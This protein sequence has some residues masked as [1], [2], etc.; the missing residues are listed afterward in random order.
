MSAHDHAAPRRRRDHQP[1]VRDTGRPDPPPGED[2]RG[3]GRYVRL[4]PGGQHDHSPR[5]PGHPDPG[6]E[7]RGRTGLHHR[8]GDRGQARP[9]H[10]LPLRRGRG[11]A[12]P[13]RDRR[14][15]H[16]PLPRLDRSAP[17]RQ[18]HNEEVTGTRYY[19]AAGQTLA[20]RTAT[21]GTAGTRLSFLAADHHGT[22]S[23]AT[24]ATTQAVTKRYSTPFGAPRGTKPTAWPDDKAFLGK[25]ADS[26]TGLT[27]IGARA[28]DPGVGQFI[29]VDPLL[30][31]D[32][33]QTLN[34]YSYA[35]QSPAANSGP[36]GTCLDPGNGR[37]QPGDNSGDPDPSFPINSSSPPGDGGPGYNGTP[38]SGGSGGPAA[39]AAPGVVAGAAAPPSLT[40]RT[41]WFAVST[42]VSLCTNR[43]LSENLSLAC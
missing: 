24:D 27:H 2:H 10:R 6:L 37:C 21:S 39:A 5:H 9:G 40:G 18:G 1:R 35:G 32:K 28:Y 26:A 42:V 34:G 29:S 11:T 20:V 3:E 4:R 12:D 19:S 41:G 7:L 15:R 36:T 17:H 25:P 13:P 23:I 33:H 14:R 30:E 16:C 38:S 43:T 8:T 31:I 22:S